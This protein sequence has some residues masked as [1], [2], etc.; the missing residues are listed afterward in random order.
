MPLCVLSPT[1]EGVEADFADLRERIPENSIVDASVEL[2][3]RDL[4]LNMAE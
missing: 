2:F 4:N 1:E 3:E